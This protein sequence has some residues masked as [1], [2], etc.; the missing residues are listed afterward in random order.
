MHEFSFSHVADGVL[1]QSVRED[2]A[3][4][5]GATARFLAKLAEIDERKLYLPLACST[6]HVFCVR[7]LGCSEQKA[8]KW[9][10]V[11]RVARRFPAI[12][13]AIADGR[14][15]KSAVVVLAHHFT[16]ENVE[17]LLRQAAGSTKAEIESLVAGRSRKKQMPIQD[18][19]SSS[20]GEGLSPGI[21]ENAPPADPGGSEP[22]SLGETLVL[23]APSGCSLTVQL[24]GESQELLRYAQ[25]LL[26]HADPSRDPPKLFG[27]ALQS[28]VADLEK[29]KFGGRTGPRSKRHGDSANP[30][31]IPVSVRRDVW[32]RDG[33]RCT[34]VSLDGKRCDCERQLEY[35]HAQ[36]V[37]KGGPSTAENLKLLCRAH[38][39]FE[40]ER[41]FGPEFM[42]R[43]R[44]AAANR[45]SA[46]EERQEVAEPGKPFD[47]DVVRCLKR[48][49]LD[50]ELAREASQHSGCPIEAPLE[51]RVKAALKWYGR[52]RSAKS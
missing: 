27:R 30:R 15:E 48:L 46:I 39:Q 4:L 42:K 37:A 41:T 19:T 23:A 29:R 6:M 36:P 26:G 1:L 16:D 11:A 52:L 47:G 18:S 51:E 45:D 17:E 10:Q 21:I 8:Y 44:Q 38:N 31:H 9:M 14:L 12:F 25:A 20:R 43:K 24:D 3:A 34:F 50:A 2:R 7:E 13:R 32:L 49:K 35:D 33:G 22:E 28:L 5:R 40:A